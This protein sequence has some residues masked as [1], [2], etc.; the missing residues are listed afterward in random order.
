MTIG[1]LLPCDHSQ[2]TTTSRYHDKNHSTKVQVSRELTLTPATPTL[3]YCC[4][5]GQ[6]SEKWNL[7]SLSKTGIINHKEFLLRVKKGSMQTLQA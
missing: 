4:Y 3:G 2:A 1:D 6:V 5:V 7:T